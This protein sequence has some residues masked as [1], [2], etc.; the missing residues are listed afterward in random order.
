MCK[1]SWKFCCSLEK[2][3]LSFCTKSLQV[4]C[5]LSVQGF[6][7]LNMFAHFLSPSYLAGGKFSSLALTLQ[8]TLLRSKTKNQCHFILFLECWWYIF[9]PQWDKKYVNKAEVWKPYW[10]WIGHK[11]PNLVF[12]KT[13][14]LPSG[15]G[16]LQLITLIWL[17]ICPPRYLALDS[18]CSRCRWEFNLGN[19]K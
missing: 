11:D 3:Y 15:D 16:M 18:C 9:F 14:P 2:F 19:N 6:H 8:G 13:H 7:T 17:Q 1:G 4:R 10:W 12:C 5:R